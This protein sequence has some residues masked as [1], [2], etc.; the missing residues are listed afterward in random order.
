[1]G[2]PEASCE[3]AGELLMVSGGALPRGFVS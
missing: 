2:D 3:V 1:V